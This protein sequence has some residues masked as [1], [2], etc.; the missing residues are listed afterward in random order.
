MKIFATKDIKDIDAATVEQE[1]ISSYDLMERASHAL[2]KEIEGRW[3][4]KDTRFVVFAGAGNNGGDALAVARMLLDNGRRV[5]AYLFN[6]GGSLSPDCEMNRDLLL[7]Q[8]PGKLTEVAR[9]FNPPTLTADDVVVDGLF[10]SGL[11]RPLEGGFA[12][13]V[14]YINGRRAQV[15]SID[16]PSGLMGEDNTRNNPDNIVR[17]DVTLTLQLPKL[18]FLFPENERYFGS[19]M[20]VDIGLSADAINSKPSCYEMADEEDMPWMLKVRGRFDHKGMFGR[21]LL[22][23]GQ[24]GMAGASVLASKACMRSGVGLLTVHV[25]KCNNVVVQSAVPEAM[26]DIDVNE[27]HFAHVPQDITGYNA[28]GIG[29]GIG[30]DVDTRSAL[31]D[32]INAAKVPMVLDADALNLIGQKHSYLQRLPQGSIITPHPGEMDRLVGRC[33]NSY[34]RLMRARELAQKCD[35]YVVLKG[36]YTVVISPD[37]ACWFNSTGNPGMAT[38]G[39]GDVLTGVILALLAQ[40]YDAST[41]AKLAV[42]AHGLA[43]DMAARINGETGMT[44]GDIVNLLPKVWKTLET[45]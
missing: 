30:Q 10:G 7:E 11:N 36:A 44:A 32:L 15:V 22:I 12:S 19:W 23:A 35:V 8:Y 42:Y 31:Y 37:G 27:T 3:T 21:A 14:R 33:S 17:A 2:T 40:G 6:K 38:G 24:L 9:E 34:E 26:T 25:P 41:A 18:A 4:D 5:D 1:G 13:V 20:L 28:I 16:I 29:P 45:V 43:G 39:S